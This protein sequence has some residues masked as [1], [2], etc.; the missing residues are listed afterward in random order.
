MY[1]ACQWLEHDAMMSLVIKLRG[2]NQKVINVQRNIDPKIHFQKAHGAPTLGHFEP[3]MGHFVPVAAIEKYL[4]RYE[5]LKDVMIVHI[6]Y[7][8]YNQIP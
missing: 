7:K 2:P 5:L 4:F 3:H 1:D 6:D 8:R